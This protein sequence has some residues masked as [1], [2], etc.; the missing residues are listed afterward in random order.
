MLWEAVLAALI[1]G[2]APWTLLIVAALLSRERPL[3]HALIFLA[4]AAFVTLLV[5]FLV[6]E[7]LGG[8]DLEDH[9][10]HRCVS[11]AIDLGLGLAIL[12]CVPSFARRSPGP[13]RARRRPR[14]RRRPP[15][16]R[17]WWERET[18]LLAVVAL[19]AFVGS[20]SPLYLAS[21]HAITKERPDS[22]VGAL[23]VLLLA[24]LVLFMAEVPILLF[25]LAPARTAALLRSANAWLAEHGRAIV[26]VAATGA[27]VY[28][29]L[30]GV[31]HLLT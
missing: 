31:V 29:T 18:G 15:D 25:A 2:F 27:G 16:A 9:R 30:T 19:G 26:I 8:S 10:H 5:G 6:V 14:F 20:P 4:T 21:L 24:A 1:A 22:A 3:R 7:A 17:P 11:P 12:L 28:F 13:K 23:E